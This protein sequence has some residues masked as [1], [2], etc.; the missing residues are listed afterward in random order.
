MLFLAQTVINLFVSMFIEV[1]LAL[2]PALLALTIFP[3]PLIFS[4]KCCERVLLF[5][6]AVAILVDLSQKMET[7]RMQMLWFQKCTVLIL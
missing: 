1:P 3:Q 7:L 5:E 4:M 6:V 2:C